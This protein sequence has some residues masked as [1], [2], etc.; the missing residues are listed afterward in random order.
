[1][2]EKVLQFA[3]NCVGL[4]RN[5]PLQI[6]NQGMKQFRLIDN[7]REYDDNEN[8]QGHEGQE[9]VVSDG[10]RQKKSLVGAEALQRL[11]RESRRVLQRLRSPR[12]EDSHGATQSGEF[13]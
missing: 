8:E 11:K 5:Q 3:H 12:S 1:M 13:S 6:P 4:S 10:A 7:V 2:L 9:G